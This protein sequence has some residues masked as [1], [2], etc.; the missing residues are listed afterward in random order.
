MACMVAV[1]FPDTASFVVMEC[2]KIPQQII[3][4]VSRILL[5]I[6]FGLVGNV[7]GALAEGHNEPNVVG[8]TCESQP[9][10]LRGHRKETTT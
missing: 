3:E 10:R 9:T 1:Y 6:D 5:S 2:F 7:G 4:S 8:A